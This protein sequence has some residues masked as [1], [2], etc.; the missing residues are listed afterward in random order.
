ML[1]ERVRYS[2]QHGEDRWI[3]FGPLDGVLH[4]VVYTKRD[5]NRWLISLRPASRRERREQRHA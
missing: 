5:G 3:A 2:P 1:V 4:A